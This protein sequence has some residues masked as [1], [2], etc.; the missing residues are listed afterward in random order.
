M[1]LILLAAATI[2]IAWRLHLDN[3]RLREQL[4]DINERI[5]KLTRE[6]P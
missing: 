2:I 4:A 6:L 3:R 1:L 5:E